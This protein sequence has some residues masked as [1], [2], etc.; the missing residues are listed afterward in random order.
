MSLN[1]EI[2]CAAWLNAVVGTVFEAYICSVIAPKV[3]WVQV[4]EMNPITRAITMVTV[5]T[6]NN[7]DILIF[8]SSAIFS[9]VATY[10]MRH[11]RGS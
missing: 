11:S 8:A 7:R 1:S 9:P 6:V 4:V 10:G 2:R 5:S 3:Y